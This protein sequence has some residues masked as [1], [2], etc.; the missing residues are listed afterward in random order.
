[1]VSHFRMPLGHW[2]RETGFWD[3]FAPLFRV[4]GV[5]RSAVSLRVLV[6]PMSAHSAVRL[7]FESSCRSFPYVFGG[8]WNKFKRLI[9]CK[10]SLLIIILA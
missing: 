5:S 3:R 2:T 4:L 9:K 1:M 10:F 6:P 7:K 8:F